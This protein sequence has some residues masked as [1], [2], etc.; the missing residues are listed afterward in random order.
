MH[1]LVKGV[2]RIIQFRLRF[3]QIHLYCQR[4]LDMDAAA[5]EVVSLRSFT[6]SVFFCISSVAFEESASIL[7]FNVC[8]LLD[9]E[10]PHE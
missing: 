5:A 6:T 3:L 8:S 7:F 1:C 9:M 10:E 4:I 2:R